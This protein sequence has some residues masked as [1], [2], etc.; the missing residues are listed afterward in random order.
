[1]GTSRKITERQLT[2]TKDAAEARK[3]SLEAKGITGDAVT[4]DPQWRHLD[5]K[6]RQII[7][8]L[9]KISA[10]E[11]VAAEL[12]QR[13]TER[14]AAQAQE[15]ADRKAGKKA[16][17]KEEAKPAKKEKK[18]GGAAAKAAKPKKEGAPADKKK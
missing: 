12:E 5:S 10:V 2:L 16:E 9:K 13:K 14:L 11:G 7:A 8:R 6:F 18:E 15:K 17:A 4:N 3:K 1:M